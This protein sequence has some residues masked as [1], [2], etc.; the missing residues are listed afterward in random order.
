MPRPFEGIRILDLTHVLA[1][2]FC[3]YQ[4]ALLGAETIKI[5]PPDEPDQVRESGTNKPLNRARM[6]TNYLSQSANKKSITLDLKS[7]RGREVLRRLVGRSDVLIENYRAGA[8][9]ELGLGY[10]DL[11]AIKPSLIYCSLT[12]FG[13]TGPKGTV[14]AYDTVIQAASGLMSVS[15]TPEVTPLKVGAPI[16]DYASGTMAAFAISSALYQR[17]LTGAGQY[18]DVSMLD[19]AMMLLSSSITAYLYDGNQLSVPRG[20]DFSSANGCCYRTKDG[21]LLMLAA[22]NHLQ[23]E[24][25]WTALGRPDIAAQ[26]SYEQIEA[27]NGQMKDELTRHF[28]TRTADEWQAFL[29]EH[30]VPGARVLTVPEALAQ[31]QIKARD[32]LFHTFPAVAGVDGPVTVPVAGFR[33]AAD[34]PRADTPPPRMGADTDAVLAQ[35]GYSSEDIKEFRRLKVI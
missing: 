19:T 23:H 26:S 8:L 28:L 24:R 31:E 27:I 22:H 32:S 33:F 15:G 18:I 5:E 7:Q 20:N 12:G 13:Q 11:H 34:G 6:G 4:L 9:A 25:L 14:T 35:F 10:A 1:G 2:P 16:L 3:S 17:T 29:E 21:G 30:R